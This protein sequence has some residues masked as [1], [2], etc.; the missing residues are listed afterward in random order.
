MADFKSVIL[1]SLRWGE[2]AATGAPAVA[3]TFPL[4]AF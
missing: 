3:K 1:F 2:G 4:F